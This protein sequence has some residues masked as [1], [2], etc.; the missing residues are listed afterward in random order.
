[1]D[2]FR[3]EGGRR[4]TGIV[5]VDGAKNAALP[6][7]AATIAMNGTARLQ[8][9]PM[10]ADV[11]TMCQLLQSL[12]AVV[13]RGSRTCSS[14]AVSSEAGCDESGLVEIECGTAHSV[15]ASYDLVSRMRAGVCVLGPL[16]AKHGRARVSLPGGCNIGH[17]P[18]DLHLRGLAA[19]GAR[20]RVEGGYIVAEASR[21][22]GCDLLLS[23]SNGST[24]TGTCNVMTAATLAKGRTVIQAAACE[25]EVIDLARFLKSAGAKIQGAGTPVIEIVGVDQL[26]ACDH[27]I[28]SD[29]IE[30]L[31]F[32]V[33]AAIT[34]GAIEIRRAPLADMASTLDVLRSSG[35]EMDCVNESWSVKSNSVQQLR[36][37]EVVA[38]PY[39]GVP[40]DT[41]AQLMAL[42]S[43]VPGTSVV[44]DRV[45]PD[46]FMHAA[47]L[48]RMGADIRVAAGTA[49]IRG[50]SRLTG[51]TV[52]ASDL[53]ASAALVLAALAA[54]G[55]S[56][57]R[58]VYH[59]DRGYA[60]FEDKLRR[61]G[62]SI[63]RVPDP[64]D[65]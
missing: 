6:I 45:F 47:E 21:L 18:V 61:L 37:V 51:A 27:T 12:G 62:A 23:G 19:L 31:T 32:A 11:A 24:V 13:R 44:T 48:V 55:R 57:I 28:I 64:H 60:G 49:M 40:T 50:V 15:E 52:M 33:A 9:I 56:E 20:I 5:D 63:Q 1:M 16:L 36:P 17:R 26:V 53:R 54:E 30:A 41:Q 43:L 58:R 38:T 14:R 4:L 39:P 3:I 29:R 22:Q 25:P 8:R 10:L 34:G 35:V 7:L 65:A 59:L 2:M 46:R 42:L